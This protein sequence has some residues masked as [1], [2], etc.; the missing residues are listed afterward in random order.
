VCLLKIR[1]G[2]IIAFERSSVEDY[3][4]L[5]PRGA[6]DPVVRAMLGS[7]VGLVVLSGI[8]VVVVIAATANRGGT[9][10]YGLRGW[11]WSGRRDRSL[12]LGGG[13]RRWRDRLLLL[14]S[15]A[16]LGLGSNWRG[17]GYP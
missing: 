10:G 16:P 4:G 14:L 6:Q 15:W 2:G 1:R 11:L 7:Q 5:P 17:R 12:C 8:V 3:A 13:G 9:D